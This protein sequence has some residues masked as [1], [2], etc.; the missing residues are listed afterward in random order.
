MTNQQDVV[1]DILKLTN[2]LARDAGACEAEAMKSGTGLA[3]RNFVRALFAWIEAISYLMRQ[4]VGKELRKQ[5][6]TED[7]MSKLLATS[8][9]SY[10][11]D[12]NGNVV[13]TKLK[14]RTSSNLLFSLK[15]FAQ[16][17]DSPPLVIDKGGRNWQSYSFALKIRDRITHPKRL[18]DLE[19]T[20]T[21][22]ETVREA[23]GMIIAYLKMF[24]SPSLVSHLK[25]KAAE[26]REKK[27]EI[28]F[29]LTE[30]DLMRFGIG[31]ET[32]KAK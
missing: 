2:V 9:R 5:P 13:E 6:L 12:G 24:L 8:E 14:T 15:S 30:E 18:E 10:Y 3:K 23:K 22:I 27:I 4:Y 32:S 29:T 21:E 31:L 7:S 25:E 17:V 28:E 16:I 19:L 26:A 1:S 11:I 20:D